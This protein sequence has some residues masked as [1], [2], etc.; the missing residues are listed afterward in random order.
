MRDVTSRRCQS[1]VQTPEGLYYISTRLWNQF[2]RISA[3]YKSHPLKS[4]FSLNSGGGRVSEHAK[5]TTQ[6]LPSESHYA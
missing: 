4:P 1:S 3:Q 2:T 5:T 6:A